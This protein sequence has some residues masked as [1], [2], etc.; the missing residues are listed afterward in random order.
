MRRYT[1]EQAAF[2]NKKRIKYLSL[3]GD[4]R[5]DWRIFLGE[6]KRDVFHKPAKRLAVEFG[7]NRQ[8]ICEVARVDAAIVW[9]SL[10]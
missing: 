8:L 2:S 7:A 9:T 4:G 5:L 6:I 1:S 3:G 10:V